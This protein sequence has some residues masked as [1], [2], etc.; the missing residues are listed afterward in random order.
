MEGCT[1]V[2]LVPISD[3]HHAGSAPQSSKTSG[4]RGIKAKFNQVQ[5]KITSNT[6][7]AREDSLRFDPVNPDQVTSSG[8]FL[9]LKSRGH[10]EVKPG[11]SGSPPQ[12]TAQRLCAVCYPL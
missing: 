5:S 7:N 10:P 3:G 8:G 9:V 2:L 6:K 11:D 12:G 1:L 4:L